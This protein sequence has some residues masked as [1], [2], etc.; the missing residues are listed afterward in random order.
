[1]LSNVEARMLLGSEINTQMSL[2]LPG[3][4]VGKVIGEGGFCKVRGVMGEV[5]RTGV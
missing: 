4:S 1:M 3:Y 5:Q 2:D